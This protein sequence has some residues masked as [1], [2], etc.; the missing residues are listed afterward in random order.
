MSFIDTLYKEKK[1]M[2]DFNEEERSILISFMMLMGVSLLLTIMS[3]MQGAPMGVVVLTALS[4]WAVTFFSFLL[5]IST[6][7]KY[8]KIRQ[9]WIKL[10]GFIPI[11]LASLTIGILFMNN[12]IT[13]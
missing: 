10:L 12:T 13:W 4:G 2:D 6:L 3:L 7:S 8:S 11:V 9:L 5:A 1:K